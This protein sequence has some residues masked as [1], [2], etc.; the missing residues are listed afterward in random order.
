M[1]VIKLIFLVVIFLAA[2]CSNNPAQ[3]TKEKIDFESYAILSCIGMTFDQ[4]ENLVDDVNSA[5]NGYMQ[6]GHMP[7]E[8]YEE[9]RELAKV[10][11]NK[12]Y[13]RKSG[14]QVHSA[15]CMDFFRSEEF[16]SIYNK[17]DPCKSRSS[18]PSSYVRSRLEISCKP[19]VK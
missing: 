3:I 12:D 4:S 10:W 7:L 9:L 15:K 16:Q 19:I 17:Y 2:S 8:A 6:K 14:G 13:P 1:G 11:M 18:S 5:L